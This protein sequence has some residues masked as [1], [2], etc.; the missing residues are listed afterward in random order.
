MGNH[1]GT[2][3]FERTGD[4]AGDRSGDEETKSEWFKRAKKTRDNGE[5]DSIPE[6]AEKGVE[7]SNRKQLLADSIATGLPS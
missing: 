7:G 2:G 1:L 3:R 5:S 4:G 6:T